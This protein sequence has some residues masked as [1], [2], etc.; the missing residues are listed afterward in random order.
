MAADGE[1]KR[2]GRPRASS[3]IW[4][5][6][7]WQARPMVRG[8]RYT[9]RYRCPSQTEAERRLANDISKIEAGTSVA[10]VKAASEEMPS[11]RVAVELFIV[12]VRGSRTPKVADHYEQ[13]LSAPPRGYISES[14]QDLPI[15]RIQT[16]QFEQCLVECSK[17]NRSKYTVSKVKK[18]VHRLYVLS[19]AIYQEA[20]VPFVNPMSGVRLPDLDIPKEARRHRAVPTDEELRLYMG[21]LHPSQGDPRA[22]SWRYGVVERQVLAT[23]SRYLGGLRVGSDLHRWKW[24]VDLFPD[25]DFATAWAP[26]NKTMQPQLFLTPEHLRSVLR[27]WWKLTGEKKDGPVFPVTRVGK[28]GDRIGLEK[29]ATGHA[30]AL[31]LDLRR[32]FLLL[33][34]EARRSG[35]GRFDPRAPRPGTRRWRELFKETERTRPVDFHSF[36]RLWVEGTTR[37]IDPEAVEGRRLTAHSSEALTAQYTGHVR[38]RAEVIPAH[39]L[40][41]P[42]LPIPRDLPGLIEELRGKVLPTGAKTSEGSNVFVS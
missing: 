35:S 29:H 27:F 32:C 12:R 25:E 26:R 7:A 42:D 3:V 13:M 19:R 4:T 5:N 20:G 28:L 14:V 6:G 9:L 21:Y 39:W 31:R 36:R 8:T 38:D 23:C 37:R 17:R 34:L 1:V 24:N 2:G 16:F 10:Q 40:P 41:R 15:D 30:K 18:A 22:T 11:F 33:H